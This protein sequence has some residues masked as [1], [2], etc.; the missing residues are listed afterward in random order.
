MMRRRVVARF[1]VA[2]ALLAALAGPVRPQEGGAPGAPAGPAAGGAEDGAAP[3]APEPEKGPNLQP[4]AWLSPDQRARLEAATRL[5]DAAYAAYQQEGATAA[6]ARVDDAIKALDAA[7]EIDPRLSLPDYDLGI[8]YQLTGEFQKAIDRLRDA[9]RKNPRFYEAMVELGDSYRWANKNGD[10]MRA[11]DDAV[12]ANPAYAHAYE[13]RALLRA[14]QEK[15]AEARDDIRHARELAPD[16]VLYRAIDAQLTL[17]L[18]GPPWPQKFTCETANYVVYTD[19]DQ[20][21]ADEVGKHAELIRRLYTTLFPRP[22]HTRRKFP[23]IVFKDANEYHQ[24]GGPRGAGGHFDPQFKQLFLFKYPNMEDTLL[25]LNHEGF[26]QFLDAL[27]PDFH[28]PQWFNEGLADFFGPSQHVPASKDT[29]EGMRL[30]PNP[31]RL[32][33]VQQMARADHFVAFERLMTMSQQEMYEPRS[34]GQNYA[35]AW[36][37]IYFLARCDDGAYF[38]YLKDYFNALRRGKDIKDA[39]KAAFGHAD[40]DAMQRRWK[41]FTLGLRQE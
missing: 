32:N 18:E 12:A 1:T 30:R 41:E 9:V 26:H 19:T 34:A 35:E 25:V 8:A 39:F 16:N 17:V 33:T 22:P 37:I 27:L 15:F 7:R 31:W 10:A 2:L 13:N 5:W 20:A 40:M 29:E 36:S 6:R 3:A 21:L 14:S 23:I 11:Y 24:N 28:P 38:N 4:P